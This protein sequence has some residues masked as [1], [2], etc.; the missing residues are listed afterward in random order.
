MPNTHCSRALV[1][2][3]PRLWTVRVLVLVPAFG[4]VMHRATANITAN[5]ATGSNPASNIQP[6]TSESHRRC[7]TEPPDRLTSRH[8]HFP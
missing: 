8:V 6:A 4:P 5:I 7:R 1:L 2:F 3:G